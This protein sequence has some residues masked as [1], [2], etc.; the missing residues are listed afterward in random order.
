[1]ANDRAAMIAEMEDDIDRSDTT[2]F[3]NKINAAIRHFQPMRFWFNE[4]RETTF[5]TTGDQQDYD[6]DADVGAF[7]YE[8]DGVYVTFGGDI[9][10]IKQV[11]YREI[12]RLRLTTPISS[13]PTSWA[14]IG[15]EGL[16]FYPTPDDAYTVRVTGHLKMDAPASDSEAD[17]VW[18]NEGYDMVMAEAKARLFAQKYRDPEG[19]TIERTVSNDARGDVEGASAGKMGTGSIRPTQF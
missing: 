10:D 18:M 9:I 12:E 11:D 14:Y 8:V 19:A 6:F 4:S 3:V 15:K 2:A 16:A 13:V 5:N 1:M 7:F 17:N